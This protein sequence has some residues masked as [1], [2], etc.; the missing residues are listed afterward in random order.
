ML[1]FLLIS[2]GKQNR[3]KRHVGDYGEGEE[4]TGY[5]NGM[6][7]EYDYD[8]ADD[9]LKRKKR[10]VNYENDDFKVSKDEFDF[11]GKGKEHGKLDSKW[12]DS[13]DDDIDDAWMKHKETWGKDDEEDFNYYA[14]G[15]KDETFESNWYDFSD[16]DG[17]DDWMKSED[18][19]ENEDSPPL[20]VKNKF[21]PTKHHL[22]NDKMR[23]KNNRFNGLKAIDEKM[24]WKFKQHQGWKENDMDFEYQLE[25][26]IEE[27]GKCD[28][29]KRCGKKGIFQELS[30]CICQSFWS[31][32]S[33]PKGKLCQ[34]IPKET[35]AQLVKVVSMFIKGN[36]P[37]MPSDNKVLRGLDKLGD[38]WE[39]KF[40]ALFMLPF[41]KTDMQVALPQKTLS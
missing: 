7:D 2:E 25:N 39:K 12:P 35:R 20:P 22:R 40:H 23:W 36:G 28:N 30:S 27:I 15:K 16:D 4:E 8:D 34:A 21:R 18:M 9:S 14:K 10:F 31:K 3:G 37:A 38:L 17:H 29:K 6:E 13:S 32:N 5:S 33:D 19:W 24:I 26:F 1:L 41:E 11:N